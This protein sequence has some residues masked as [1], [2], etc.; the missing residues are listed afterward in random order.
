MNL[1]FKIIWKFANIKTEFNL[2][3]IFPKQ[4]FTS[5]INIYWVKN[6]EIYILKYP[7]Y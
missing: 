6:I 5:I 7:I 1:R 3:P 2:K 4:Y